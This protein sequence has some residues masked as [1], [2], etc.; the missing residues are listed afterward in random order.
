MVEFR[1]DA[2]SGLGFSKLAVGDAWAY[3]CRCCAFLGGGGGVSL[4]GGAS[5]LKP[6]TWGGGGVVSLRG[7][8]GVSGETSGG[9]A[10]ASVAPK[11]WPGAP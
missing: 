6:Q 10:R 5:P 2:Q 7:G 3:H 9:R 11:T 1:T 4:Q 8:G